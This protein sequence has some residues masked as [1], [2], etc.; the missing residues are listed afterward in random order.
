MRRQLVIARR[1]GTMWLPASDQRLDQVAA[2]ARRAG[3]RALLRLV[4][5]PRDPGGD[6]PAGQRAPDWPAA[7]ALVASQPLGPRLRTPAALPLV[8]RLRVEQPGQGALLWV[9]QPPHEIT[10]EL[11]GMQFL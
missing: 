11:A 6:A 1:D 2:P 10:P 7:A 5:S 8:D 3:E 4:R 9:Q